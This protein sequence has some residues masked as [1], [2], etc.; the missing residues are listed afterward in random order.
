VPEADRIAACLEHFVGGQ[1]VSPELAAKL[2]IYLDLLLRWNARMNLTAVRDPEDIVTRHFGE[3]LFAARLLAESGSFW[4]TEGA[5]PT[6][7][8]IGS[9]A[10]FPGIPIKLYLPR[11][12]LTLIE[13]RNKK[14][15][16][17]REVVR[18]LD[19][20]E[21][22]VVCTRVETW[23]RRTTVVTL[24]AV[25]RFSRVLPLAAELVAD[26]GTLCL[27]TGGSQ[28]PA[29]QPVP[30]WRVDGPI[31]VPGSKARVVLLMGKIES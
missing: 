23:K 27:L 20:P 6:L 22:E 3:S 30:G 24:R 15:T 17:L 26:A 10:G 11:I 8:D 29:M 1:R 9:G 21:V 2:K 5:A 25:E 7:T 28:V 4:R 16:F 13:S 31:S 19:L 18:A 14:A 12:R